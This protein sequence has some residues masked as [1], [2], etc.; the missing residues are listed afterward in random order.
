MVVGY[1][2]FICLKNKFIAAKKKNFKLKRFVP[3]E[4]LDDENEFFWHG[5]GEVGKRYLFWNELSFL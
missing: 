4:E 5:E 2:H 3:I 1:F